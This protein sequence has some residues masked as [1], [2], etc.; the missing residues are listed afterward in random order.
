VRFKA[1]TQRAYSLS[2]GNNIDR[3]MQLKD[4][5]QTCNDGLNDSIKLARYTIPYKI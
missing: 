4:L 2:T 3:N 5:C 1:V